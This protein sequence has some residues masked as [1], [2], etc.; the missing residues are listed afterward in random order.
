MA[1]YATVGRELHSGYPTSPNWAS[2][3]AK[4]HE[5]WLHLPEFRARSSPKAILNHWM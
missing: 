5:S 1:H 3:S 4:L 2:Q